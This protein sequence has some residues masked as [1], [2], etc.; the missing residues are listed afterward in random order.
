MSNDGL[1]GDQSV[2]FDADRECLLRM[3]IVTVKGF[4]GGKGGWQEVRL[5]LATNEQ[6][7]ERMKQENWFQLGSGLGEEREREFG[8]DRPIL[9]EVM[10]SPMFQDKFPDNLRQILTPEW[11]QIERWLALSVVQDRGEVQVGYRTV[12][13][14]INLNRLQEVFQLGTEALGIFWDKLQSLDLGSFLPEMTDDGKSNEAI[15]SVMMETVVR[16]FF[17]EEE[18]EFVRIEEEVWQVMFQ[19]NHG[20]WRCYARLKQETQQ[21]LFYSICP[22]RVREEYRL[23]IA[24]FLT[25]VNYGMILGNFELDF[26]DGEIRYKTSIDVEG[27]RLSVALIRPLVYANVTMMDQYL[28]GLVAMMESGVSPQEAIAIVEAKKSLNSDDTTAK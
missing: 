23:A 27:D 19:G 6:D 1:D 24:E 22:V 16:A 26:T 9:I 25:K 18:W 5:V 11:L 8:G 12:W 7:Y 13:D 21:F 14:Q 3:R 17:E 4:S 10:C 20:Q 15:N 28:P 2:V